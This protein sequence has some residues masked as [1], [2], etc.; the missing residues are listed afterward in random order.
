MIL[1]ILEFVTNAAIRIGINVER[2]NE[3]RDQNPDGHLTDDQRKA[4]LAEALY[5]VDAM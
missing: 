1:R 3:L 4:L 5:A 2:F